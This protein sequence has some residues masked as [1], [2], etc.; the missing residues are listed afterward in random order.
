VHVGHFLTRAALRWAHRPAW[1]EGDVAVTFR[2]AEAHAPERGRDRRALPP[3]PASYKKPA[4]VNFVTDLSK[5]ACGKVPERE[6]REQYWSGR[7]RN[8]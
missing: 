3:W 6:L 5:N 1:L 7:S 8:V 4:S 2:E